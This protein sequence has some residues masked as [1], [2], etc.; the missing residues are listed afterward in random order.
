M[1]DTTDQ[2]WEDCKQALLGAMLMARYHMSFMKQNV[3]ILKHEAASSHGDNIA[4]RVIN[5]FTID[6]SYSAIL[7]T[8][9]L[10]NLLQHL[11][12]VVATYDRVKALAPHGTNKA[13]A[14]VATIFSILVRGGLCFVCRTQ[15]MKFT[16]ACGKTNY[17]SDACK[18][19]D[20][21]LHARACHALRTIRARVELMAAMGFLPINDP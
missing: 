15:Q 11:E 21:K 14:Q 9:K 3:E 13:R 19:A 8:E 7:T 18:S 10:V 20:E 6:P 5:K 1:A 16:C 17:C 12:V 2:G 4:A